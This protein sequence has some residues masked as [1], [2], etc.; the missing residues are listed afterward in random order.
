MPAERCRVDVRVSTGRPSGRARGAGRRRPRRARSAAGPATTPASSRA[1][2]RCRSTPGR[3]GR[4]RFQPAVDA[5]PDPDHG[6]QD[7]RGTD[8]QQRRPHPVDDQVGD[9][10]PVAQRDPEV[11]GQRVLQ[12]RQELLAQRL[13][14]TVGLRNSS[15]CS[16]VLNR[17]RPRVR[18]GSPGIT[19]N[20]KKLTTSMNAEAPERAEAAWPRRTGRSV[21]RRARGDVAGAS[22]AGPSVTRALPPS[23]RRRISHHAAEHDGQP[24]RQHDATARRRRARAVAHAA[25]AALASSLS[26]PT[27]SSTV[28]L[29]GLGGRTH[30]E[31]V[32]D[33]V[34]DQPDAARVGLRLRCRRTGR[35]GRPRRSG[36]TPSPGRARRSTGSPASA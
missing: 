29:A 25:V 4:P 7:R 32:V 1:S 34:L 2:A 22:A 14:E 12:E 27:A 28:A 11:T 10:H 21:R 16:G 23:P 6:G 30:V 26:A 36:C 18:A 8:Q 9:R 13:V 31:V 17:P 15:S 24:A 19:R 5:D 33:A 35:C 3:T 20:R